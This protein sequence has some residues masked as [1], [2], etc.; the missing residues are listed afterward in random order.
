MGSAGEEVKRDDAGDIIFC[1]E[2]F[3][4][5]SLGGGVAGEVDDF[6]WF[7]FGEFIDE[8][9]VAAATRWIKDDG[10]IFFQVVKG[11]FA[12]GKDGVGRGAR[13]VVLELTI[14]ICVAFH[15][16]Q[17]FVAGDG[18]AN[19][20]DAGIEVK[21]FFSG[22]FFGDFFEGEFVDGKVNLEETVGA[23]GVFVAEDGVGEVF[24]GRVGLSVLEKA[25]GDFAGL[26]CA[27][28]ERLVFAGFFVVGI[29]FDDDFLS[30]GKNFRTFYG[31]SKDGDFAVG[32]AAVE[33]EFDFV[34]VVVPVEG[35]FHFVTIKPGLTVGDGWLDF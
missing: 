33:G 28:E 24:E 4:V 35:I 15:E 7:D 17:I 18:E 1:R 16:C 20:A 14:G 5:T 8:V 23:V 6:F 9:F 25:A 10:L 11:A 26:V 13:A 22:D 12:F 32:A 21:D 2:K 19:S 34:G 30:F 29:K 31:A 3:E 27:K